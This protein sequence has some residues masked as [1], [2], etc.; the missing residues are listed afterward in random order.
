VDALALA[1]TILSVGAI[2]VAGLVAVIVGRR[3]GID[4]VEAQAD[5]EV[6]RLVEAQA[7]R[8]SVLEA[9]NRRLTAQVAALTTELAQVR[10]ELDIEKRVTARARE[11]TTGD[12]K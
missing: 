11:R 4:Q 7:M 2:A 9:E 12:G 10:A 1:S 8:L 6:K 5:G 3:R